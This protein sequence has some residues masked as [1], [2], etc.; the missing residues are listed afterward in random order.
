MDTGFDR[1]RVCVNEFLVKSVYFAYKGVWD[2]EIL[3]CVLAIFTLGFSWLIYP[4]FAEKLIV[5]YYLRKGWK[6]KNKTRNYSPKRL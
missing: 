5:D 3:S 4:F 1:Y 2:Q 6:I